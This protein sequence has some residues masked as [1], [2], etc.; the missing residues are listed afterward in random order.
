MDID[1]EGELRT[2]FCYYY[3]KNGDSDQVSNLGVVDN[4]GRLKI[5][6]S[7][8][9]PFYAAYE[10][11]I[12][13]VAWGE[14]YMGGEQGMDFINV[15]TK[16]LFIGYDQEPFEGELGLIGFETP[17]RAEM[18]DD[19]AGLKIDF[20]KWGFKATALYSILSLGT[21]D[22]NLSIEIDD[23]FIDTL[24]D[25]HL[26]Y[27]EG[28]YELEDKTLLGM[29]LENG[30]SA[31]Y[32]RLMDNR[33]DYDY[34]LNWIGLY[35]EFKWGLVDLDL[36]FS[37]NTGSVNYTNSTTVPVNA[38][39]LYSKLNFNVFDI[40]DVF[41]RF[42]YVSGNEPGT[43][44]AVN[45][46]QTIGARG[47]IDTDLGILFGGSPF[48][49]QAYFSDRFAGI[50]TRRNI[51][52]GKVRFT[53]PG[54]MI[55]EFGAKRDFQKIGLET[56]VVFG[57]GRLAHKLNNYSVLGY[58]IDIHN[59][60]KLAKKTYLYLSMGMLLHGAALKDAYNISHSDVFLGGDPDPTFKLDGMVEIEF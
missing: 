36:G 35:D 1:F 3:N 53:D 20:K 23:F 13:N 60:L 43:S 58:E 55:L 40:V 19:L 4:R 8:G 49:Q 56:E 2:R 17:L 5:E 34:I 32:M 25:T 15:E 24:D 38:Y 51:T 50:D 27:F 39:Y 16:N 52:E 6:A 10:L 18:D 46:F 28:G 26:L 31:W 22:T 59:K 12:G 54:F 42:N 44:N 57:I 14:T 9:G 7:P 33:Y 47:R 30:V 11:E 48:N 37:L 45:Q 21:N 29:E 41:A